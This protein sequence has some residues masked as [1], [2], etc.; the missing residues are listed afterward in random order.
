ML[1][2]EVSFSSGPAKHGIFFRKIIIYAPNERKAID[3]FDKNYPGANLLHIEE[4]KDPSKYATGDVV[5]DTRYNVLTRQ[6]DGQSLFVKVMS[7]D[8]D[9]KSYLVS[10]CSISG[11]LLDSG[12]VY[13]L[14]E[15]SIRPSFKVVEENQG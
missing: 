1:R 3:I 2:Y 8:P 5:I 7:T 12:N 14:Y 10:P 15:D 9:S 11:V 4:K 6:S 13:R